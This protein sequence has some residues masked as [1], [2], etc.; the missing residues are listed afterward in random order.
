MLDL[1]HLQKCSEHEWSMTGVCGMEC[2]ISGGT[3][4]SDDNTS[5]SNGNYIGER[6]GKSKVAS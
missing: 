4:R 6:V 3:V 2:L 5:D 1:S